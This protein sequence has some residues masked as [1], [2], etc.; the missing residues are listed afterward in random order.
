MRSNTKRTASTA[1]FGPTQ[2]TA[3]N[4]SKK[5]NMSSTSSLIGGAHGFQSE[6]LMN[7]VHTQASLSINKENFYSI[8]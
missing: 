7:R 5:K 6:R 8:R 1:R 2:K 4:N 3:S